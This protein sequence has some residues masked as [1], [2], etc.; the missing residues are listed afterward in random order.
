VPGARGFATPAA[1]AQ[2]LVS[3]RSRTRFVKWKDVFLRSA[4]VIEEQ[5]FTIPVSTD[6]HRHSLIC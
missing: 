1:R 4:V 5:C 6:R 2:Q 3:E